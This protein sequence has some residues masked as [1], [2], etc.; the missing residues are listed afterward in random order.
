MSYAIYRDDALLASIIWDG[1]MIIIGIDGLPVGVYNY[2]LV[3]YDTDS[4]TASDTVIVSVT[5]ESTVTNTSS[6]TT[7]TT[8]AT[9]TNTTGGTGAFQLITLAISVGSA[10]VIVVFAAAACRSRKG[11]I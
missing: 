3:V 7:T 10:I 6:T 2:T 1:G 11:G 4:N 9:T 5:S 8:S